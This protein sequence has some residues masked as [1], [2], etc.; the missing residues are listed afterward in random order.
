MNANNRRRP[1][2]AG[3]GE[4]LATVRHPPRNIKDGKSRSNGPP[5][6]QQQIRGQTQD[7]EDHPENLSFHSSIVGGVRKTAGQPPK[8]KW[9]GVDAPSRIGVCVREA[10]C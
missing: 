1:P 7:E 9:A 10:D 2:V 5:E 6:W 4:P 8:G 3:L